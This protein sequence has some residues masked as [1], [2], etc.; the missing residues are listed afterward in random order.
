MRLLMIEPFYGGSHRNF[1]DGLASHSRHSID[2]IT[3]PDRFWKWRMRGAALYLAPLLPSPAD[4]DLLVVSSLLSL[5]DLVMLLGGCRLPT[6]AYFHENQLTYPMGP[7]QTRD[8]HFGITDITTAIAADLVLFNSNAHRDAFL[9]ALP[10]FIRAMP[11]FHP[12]WVVDTISSKSDIC[13]PGCDMRGMIDTAPR[14]H[15]PLVVWNHRWEHD[16]D[17]DAF[18]RVM[19]RLRDAGVDF[20]LAVL[21]Q[22]YRRRPAVFDTLPQAFA[23]QL[24]HMGHV[25]DRRGYAQWLNRATV[26][27]STA[28]QENFGMAVVEAM[29]AGCFPLLPNRLSYPEL[30]PEQ[31]Q[32]QCLY[33]DEGDLEKRLATVLARPDAVAPVRHAVAAAMK[34]F[35]W[36]HRAAAFDDLMDQVIARP[37]PAN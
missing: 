6:V 13:Y 33:R 8:V 20:R 11:E 1:A 28:H 2:L 16:K 3:L 25:S 18:F 34:R 19:G 22:S 36:P 5:S 4:Y 17:P 32:D 29:A 37:L 15:P 26:V 23:T 27:V 10:E 31:Y 7:D 14:D 24:I 35:D 12:H 30:I 9:S 21:G